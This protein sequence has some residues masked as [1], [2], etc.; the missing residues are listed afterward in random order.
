MVIF[1]VSAFKIKLELN[2]TQV[3]LPAPRNGKF[4]VMPVSYFTL[5]FLFSLLLSLPLI[6]RFF[7]LFF[8][9]LFFFHS[10]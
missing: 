10:S 7:S 9:P 1:C 5:V 4:S 2:E 3:L 8:F 6:I